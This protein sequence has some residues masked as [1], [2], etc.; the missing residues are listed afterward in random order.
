MKKMFK[1]FFVII[2]SMVTF[3]GCVKEEPAVSNDTKT[4]QFFAE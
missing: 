1:S 2:A 3:A 4:V